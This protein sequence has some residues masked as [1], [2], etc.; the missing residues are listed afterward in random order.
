MGLSLFVETSAIVAFVN[1][2]PD[3]ARVLSALQSNSE[4][5]TSP[6]VILEAA[7]VLSSR[8]NRPP[9]QTERL[10][11]D[12]LAT[13]GV[14]VVPIDDTTAALAVQAFARYGKGRGSAAKLN[15]SDCLSY[16]CAK[17]HRVPLLYVGDDFA[18]TDLA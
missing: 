4:M 12:T 1:N 6:L 17:Q 7:M 10:V 5:I 2:E 8:L 16:A 13:A 3:A 18:A 14:S 9:E 15:M 11:R